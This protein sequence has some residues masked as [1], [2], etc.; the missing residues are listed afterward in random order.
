M[1]IMFKSGFEQDF[2]DIRVIYT[3]YA[4]G[5]AFCVYWIF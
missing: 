4:G 1:G 2:V 5:N 3:M